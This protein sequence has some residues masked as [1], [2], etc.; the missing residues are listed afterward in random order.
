M[1]PPR[2]LTAN[3]W[4]DGSVVQGRISDRAL[5]WALGQ[6][7]EGSPKTKDLRPTPVDLSQWRDPAVGWGLILPEPAAPLL[8][9]N[10]SL[11][12][13]A[14][15]PEPIRRLVQERGPAPV[16]HFGRDASGRSYLR[17]YVTGKGFTLSALSATPRGVAPDALPQY[18]LIYGSPAEIPWRLQYILNSNRCV[19]RLDLAGEALNNYVEALIH[20]FKG[21]AA[22]P[23][24]PLLWAVDMGDRITPLM[25]TV[26]AKPVYERLKG[27]PD[28][29]LHATFIDGSQ[30][31]ASV[32]A[33]TA[34]LGKSP[35]LIIT[36]SHGSAE[37]AGLGLLVDQH[38]RRLDLAQLLASW[39]PDGAIWYAHACYSAGS[40]SQSQFGP[41]FAAD[42]PVSQLLS[43]VSQAG[44]TVA[45]M[46][47]ALLG[48]KRPLRAFVGHVE[49]TFDWT[50]KHPQTEQVLTAPLVEALYQQL[51]LGSPVALALRDRF[52]QIGTLYAAKNSALDDFDRGADAGGDL[53]FYELAARDIQSTVILG[54]PTVA[55]DLPPS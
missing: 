18:L 19:G 55:L 7:V 42:D 29:A 49:P 54:D 41:L 22:Q 11:G 37:P 17:N 1:A 6:G 51:Y 15:A 53:L 13:A 50:L 23:L 20:G 12:A 32:E 4:R 24:D 3:A 26:I 31:E 21:S 5:G 16:F 27:D 48:A 44:S 45:T 33:L 39:Q 28:I 25:R 52:A 36:T 10:R 38:G 40:D 43:S 2:E 8:R 47:R 14:G 9:N 35:G 34:A 30:S 46:P